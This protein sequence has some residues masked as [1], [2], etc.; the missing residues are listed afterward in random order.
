MSD[1]ATDPG[2]KPGTATNFIRDTII[3][4]IASGKYDGRVVTRF[5]PE[6]NGY[7]HIGHAKAINLDFNL[8]DEFG[9]VCN[10]R[11]DDTNPETEDPEYV[12][13]IIRDVKWL[14]FDWDDRL[15]F[16]SDY[17]EKLYECAVKLIKDGKA[18]VD[19]Q[20]DEELRATRGTVTEPGTESPY[21]NRPV[22]ENLDL[23]ERMRAGEFKDGE[24]VLR[25]KID[26]AATNMKLRD[27]LLYR[28]RHAHHYRRGDDWCIYPMYDYAH[29]LSDAI[30]GITHSIC[31]L[32]FENNR[33]L[34]D[35]VLDNAWTVPRP[36]QYE[37]NRLHLT[38]TVLSKRK[39]LQL[40]DDG[41]V[42]GWDDPRM[43]TLT[44]QRRRGVTPE[45]IR[46]LCSRVG[47]IKTD[48]RVDLGLYDY[49]IRNDLNF[50]APRVMAVVR[51]LKV[52]IT[53]YPEGQTEW[54]DAPYW[55]HDVPKEGSRKVPFSRTLFIERDDFMETPV[56]K[57]YRLAPGREV[58]LRY[59]YFI[60][61]DEGI[62]DPKTGEIEEL[63]C[64][65]DP[66]TR[67]GD[68]ADGRKVKATLHWVSAEHSVS[69]EVRL[70]DRLFTEAEPESQDED[71][72]S[73]INPESRIVVE[74][75]RIEP[76]VT[77]DPADTR[78]QFERQGY[79]WRDPMDSTDERPVF[80]RIVTLRD[81]WAKISGGH[82]ET[83]VERVD[84]A[85]A[86][87]QR[88]P[89]SSSEERKPPRL[90][91]R[92]RER[93]ERFEAD[94]ELD[95]QDAALLSADDAIAE[96]FLEAVSQ[97]TP[98][99]SA[100]NWI[101]NEL[102]RELKGLDLA[103]LPITASHLAELIALMDDDTISGRIAKD[104]F[105]EMIESGE[106]PGSIVEAKGLRQLTDQSELESV[107][108]AVVEGHPDK[109]ETYRGGKTG[110][111]GFFVGQVMRRTDGKANPELARKLIEEELA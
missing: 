37:F 63:R 84:E 57:F 71:W 66:K 98:P 81:S 111:I 106:K 11:F 76:S 91:A 31:T 88:P 21:R 86:A 105:A 32:E 85:K 30:E 42:D 109:A 5:P 26:M 55:P 110:L 65:Y 82:V 74:D 52:V 94:Y 23:F 107:V 92:R 48:T 6:P 101:L 25:A 29:P 78:Y 3:E 9:G 36:H 45:A 51:P 96:F 61:C 70:Y 40:V 20:S 41:L 59:G 108:K 87:P 72:K 38:Y 28:I 80:N 56:K 33:A 27:P 13:A 58:R 35:W 64:T 47:V 95:S 99:L 83:T 103:D 43:P 68:S 93:A 18:Y 97:G 17:F 46:D 8:A 4:D 19:S 102:L 67:G 53:N 1:A 50:R 2:S 89:V 90:N 54:L 62:K 22:E 75:A 49:A 69:A 44:G 79:F 16:A 7:L 60:T 39:L 104:V 12:A 34:Y 100:A 14:G 73:F 15:Y 24:H 10:L 77:D